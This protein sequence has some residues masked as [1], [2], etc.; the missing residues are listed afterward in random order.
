[1][2]KRSDIKQE[3]A[4][5][6]DGDANIF[7]TISVSTRSSIGKDVLDS[8]DS[9]KAYQNRKTADIERVLEVMYGDL[10]KPLRELQA[11]CLKSCEPVIAA[12]IAKRFDE[13]FVMLGGE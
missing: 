3:V 5:D 13:V 11:M 2:V 9:E 10:A 8:I 12:E 6:E 7:T 1:M 4:I